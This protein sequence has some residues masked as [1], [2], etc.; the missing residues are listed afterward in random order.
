MKSKEEIIKE[1]YGSFWLMLSNNIDCKGWC[2]NKTLDKK[3]DFLD[4][5][6]SVGIKRQIKSN[7]QGNLIFRPKSLDGIENNNGWIKIESE[8][9]LPKES[10]LFWIVEDGYVI[11]EP[12][13][14]Y[15]STKRWVIQCNQYPSHYKPIQKPKPPLY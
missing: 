4:L 14:Y 13:K 15:K 12:C 9:D 5:I 6:D 8:T 7:V 10:G 3:T 1:A 2:L 11:N